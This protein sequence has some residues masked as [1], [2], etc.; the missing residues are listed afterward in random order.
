MNILYSVWR[1]LFVF[2]SVVLFAATAIVGLIAS[3]SVYAQPV[4]FEENFASHLLDDT[5]D[6]QGRVESVYDWGIDRS[7]SLIENIRWLFYPDASGQWGRLYDLMR[8][9]VFALFI[10]F[11]VLSGVLMLK[12]ANDGAK[13][14]DI[15]LNMMFMILGAV[16]FFSATRILGVALNLDGSIGSEGLV[17]NVENNLLFQVLA[18]L[19]AAAFF[20]AIVMIVRYGYQVVSAMDS[21][22][23]FKSARQWVLNVLLALIFIK[24]IDYVYFVAQTPDLQSQATEI[25]VDISRVLLW[26]LGALFVIYILYAGFSLLF[27]AGKTESFDRLKNIASAIALGSLVLFLFLLVMYQVVQEFAA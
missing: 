17:S 10:A 19:K 3:H 2:F 5:P 27:G 9:I 1:C 12:D 4:S 6:A 22:D 26:I 16:I 25:I 13:M 14:K 7:A 11:L 21:Q 24:I 18:F 23:K 8:P 15:L 20:A